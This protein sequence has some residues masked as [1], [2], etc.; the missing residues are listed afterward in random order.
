V[1]HGAIGAAPFQALYRGEAR[2]LLSLTLSPEWYLVVL[3]LA[4]ASL[5][6]SG[7]AALLAAAVAMPLAQA[8][9]SALHGHY[10]SPARGA[11]ERAARIGLTALMHLAQPLARLTGRLRHGLTPWRRRGAAGPRWP[12]LA[13]DPVWSERWRAPEAW[14]GLLADALREQGTVVAS[15]GAYDRWDLEARGGLAG[16]MRLLTVAEEHG[17]GRQQ[18]RVRARPRVP[19]LTSSAAGLGAVLGSLAWWQGATGAAL[20]LGAAAVALVLWCGVDC[21]RA[22]RAA[23]VALQRL[24]EAAAG[25]LR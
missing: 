20:V 21:G 17:A 4:A 15:G 19:L 12:W 16:G 18:I 25:E 22:A 2:G 7:A 11:L 23:D 5:A 9:L 8:L 14:V 24:R 13:P 10:T 6:W 1:Y 3:A